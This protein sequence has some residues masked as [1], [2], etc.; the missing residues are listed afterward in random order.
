M[1]PIVCVPC[2]VVVA[3]CADC[4]TRTRFRFPRRARR[5]ASCSCG[6]Q[7]SRSIPGTCPS[8]PGA[9]TDIRCPHPP[10]TTPSPVS[11]AAHTD[12]APTF[13]RFHSGPESIASADSRAPARRGPIRSGSGSRA[14]IAGFGSI[15][16]DLRPPRQRLDQI[17]PAT[18]E[19]PC[20][21]PRSSGTRSPGLRAPPEAA[22]AIV[23]AVSVK[24]LVDVAALLGLRRECRCAAQIRLLGKTIRR[25]CSV[26]RGRISATR[27]TLDTQR[28]SARNGVATAPDSSR[29]RRRQA[30]RSDHRP[31][32]RRRSSRPLTGRRA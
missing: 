31:E 17:P 15:R 28:G 4:S 21:S 30:A 8:A 10:T 19:P 2:V 14:G 12:G 22:P 18:H 20:W 27:W 16:R 6:W 13:V 29:R 23:R 7:S 9:S 32:P 25:S 26:G 3:R 24:L 5:R 1:I 11:P